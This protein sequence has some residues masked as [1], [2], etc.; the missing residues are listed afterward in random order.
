MVKIFLN[1][2]SFANIFHQRNQKIGKMILYFLFLVLLISFP[3]NYQIVKNDGFKGLNSFSYDL[4]LANPSWLPGNLPSDMV[5]TKSGLSYIQD[6]EYS[7]QTITNEITYTVMINP[8]EEVLDAKNTIVF[9]KQQLKYFDQKGRFLTGDYDKVK[10]AIDFS[11]LKTLDKSEAVNIFFSIV[12]DAFNPYAVFYSIMA[13]TFIQIGMN[14]LLVLILGLIFL[15]IR[16]NY[17]PVTHFMQNIKIII[18]SM[19][20]PSLISIVVGIIGVIEVNSFTV[21]LFQFLT[22]LI[23]LLAI[24]KGSN[25]KEIIT[26][27]V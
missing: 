20:I 3:L 17:K 22:P 23:A 14:I 4:R 26:K 2:F 1:S 12:D 19:T 21:V 9:E 25:E 27:H 15:L 24:Y 6:Q 13:N 11:E 7:F 16:V 10:Q 18:T 8:Q 5:I